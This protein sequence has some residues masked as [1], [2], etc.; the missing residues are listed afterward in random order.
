MPMRACSLHVVSLHVY[1]VKGAR[2]VDLARAHFGPLGI[3]GDRRWLVVDSAGRHVT[4]RENHLLAGVSVEPTAGGLRL[5]VDGAP[6]LLVD[7]PRGSERRDIV[8]FRDKV[9]AA[10]A[11]TR[12]H[13]WLSERLGQKVQLVYMDAHAHREKGGAWTASP[14]PI[15]FADNY[16]VLV[17]SRGSLAALNAEIES[18]GAPA[19]PMRRF[20]PNIVIDCGDAWLEDGWKAAR[21]GSVELAFVRPCDRCE[22]TTRDQASGRVMGTEPLATLGRVRRSGD[23]RLRGKVLFGAYAAVRSAGYATVGD[24]VEI[25]EEQAPFAIMPRV[26][27]EV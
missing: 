5:S 18:R 25:I 23:E 26:G 13:E 2:A 24:R 4:Q 6:D 7:T 8:I 1:P 9:N 20:R 19:G 14:V 27:A 3:D 17:T 21:V 15:S 12:A 22:A 10:L 16:P 11:A